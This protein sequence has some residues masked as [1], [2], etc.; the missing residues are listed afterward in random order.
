MTHYNNIYYE[1]LEEVREI[2]IVEDEV[3]EDYTDIEALETIQEVSE[4]CD[5]SEQTDITETEFIE[6]IDDFPTF[7]LNDVDILDAIS[8]DIHEP[9]ISKSKLIVKPSKDDDEP[10]VSEDERFEFIPSLQCHFLTSLDYEDERLPSCVSHQVSNEK[11]EETDFLSQ[12]SHQANTIPQHVFY[13]KNYPQVGLEY[14]QEESASKLRAKR[15]N[16]K[17]AQEKMEVEQ[18]SRAECQDMREISGSNPPLQCQCQDPADIN[19]DEDTSVSEEATETRAPNIEEVQAGLFED[20]SEG[21]NSPREKDNSSKLPHDEEISCS[22]TKSASENS[23]K[24]DENI[25][26]QS[27]LQNTENNEGATQNDQSSATEN[28]EKEGSIQSYKLQLTRIKELQ[29]LVEDELEEFET[30]RKVKSNLVQ[31][32]ETQIVNIVKGIEFK[33]EIKI[34]QLTEED[35]DQDKTE[36]DVDLI[37]EI[38]D[39]N[40]NEIRDEEDEDMEEEGLDI[41]ESGKDMSDEEENL[42]HASCTLK[43]D[44]TVSISSNFITSSQ[45]QLAPEISTNETAP[46]ESLEEKT[47][48]DGE[49]CPRTDEDQERETDLKLQPRAP[50]RKSVSLETKI[51][52]KQLLESLLSDQRQAESSPDEEKKE[53]MPKPSILKPNKSSI[54]LSLN[55]NVKKQSYRIKFRIKVNDKSPKESS[56][57]R[58]LFGCFGGERLFHSNH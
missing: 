11:T 34:T 28:S 1:T 12:I 19:N 52:D 42:I 45:T 21:T 48:L 54:T 36:D 5:T 51:R 27:S 31:A 16:R 24:E 40:T 29:K 7:N 55:E 39:T 23:E 26:D 13:L 38:D 6:D 37:T 53:I 15:E 47:E 25:T 57:L 50:P 30:K 18:M 43:R 35:E 33:S 4:V 20:F 9:I 3:T 14:H 49:E 10:V 56:V 44:N 58:Y 8:E 2:T 41:S 22:E 32:T 46:E 17:V